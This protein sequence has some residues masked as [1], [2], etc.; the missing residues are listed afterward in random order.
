MRQA[1]HMRAQRLAQQR[2]DQLRRFRRRLGNNAHA[3]AW[4][5]GGVIFLIVQWREAIPGWLTSIQQTEAGAAVTSAV[6]TWWSTMQSVI[7]SPDALDT[8]SPEYVLFFTITVF[9]IASIPV[10]IYVLR[11]VLRSLIR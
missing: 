6:N 7:A 9:G 2:A 5:L 11:G 3:F 4:L 8:S 1:R 10:L